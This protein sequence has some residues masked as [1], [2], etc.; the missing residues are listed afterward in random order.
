MQLRTK[1]NRLLDSHKEALLWNRLV[2]YVQSV[3]Q[4][5]N[6]HMTGRTK[7]HQAQ[8]GKQNQR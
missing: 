6:L 8:D 3:V 4:S 2:V 5:W 1:I 7:D